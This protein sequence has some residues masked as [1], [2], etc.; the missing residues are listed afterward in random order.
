VERYK[1]QTKRY[2]A[3]LGILQ[4]IGERHGA[5]VSYQGLETD[6]DF[7][8]AI[9]VTFTK[10]G[11]SFAVMLH[12]LDTGAGA[13]EFQS[14]ASPGVCALSGKNLATTSASGTA[15]PDNGK[16]T[17]PHDALAG[18]HWASIIQ[19][20]GARLLGNSPGAMKLIGRLKSA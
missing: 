6:S 20:E 17:R 12:R 2:N 19:Q 1:G 10:G 16:R 7:A 15:Q 8:T 11:K 13:H 14:A 9:E 5:N 4:R 18:S 3:A